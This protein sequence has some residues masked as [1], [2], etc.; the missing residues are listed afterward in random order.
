LS[1]LVQDTGEIGSI[2]TSFGPIVVSAARFLADQ[3]TLDKIVG[4][5]DVSDT[6][7]NVAANLLALNADPGVDAITAD[8]G[9]GTLSGAGV[10][11]PNFSET[12]WGTNLTVS[13]ALLTYAGA[14]T[15]GS[16]STLSISS[17]DTLSLTGTASLS[18]TTSGLG[19]LALGGSATIDKGGT[20]SVSDW[21]ISGAGADVKL[22]KNLSYAGS[23]S[24]G[25]DDT[26]MLSG[27]HLL[28][29]GAATFAGG[30]VE[31]SN[32]LYTEGTTTVS[33]LT[34]GGTVEW[35]NTSAVNQSGGNVTLGDNI[36][37]DEAI[38]YNTPKATYDIIDDSG[39]GLGASTASYIHNGGLLEKTGGTETSTIAP[40]VTNTGTIKVAAATLDL[41]GA[42]TG[43]GSDEISGA[44]TLQFDA[45]V[46][47]DQTV[48][49]SGVGGEVALHKP[50]EFAGQISGFDTTNAGSKDKIEVAEHWVFTGFKEN[51]GS[52]TLGFKNNAGSTISH[53]LIG[54]YSG[55]FT[56]HTQAN[57][58]TVITYTGAPGLDSLLH[59]A[60]GAAATGAQA[61]SASPRQ[62]GARAA[63]GA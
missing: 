52:T 51:A 61:D 43:K 37:A 41:Q 6:A 10:N 54:N 14:F 58:S 34:I 5:F 2:T 13:E 44:S 48:D 9:D 28:L 12:G 31:G 39:I 49:F 19:T 55:T 1:T 7:G 4:G 35:E 27:G 47:A 17:A 59:P 15:Q 36:A 21:S 42:V 46:A 25:A 62:A 30:T 50:G 60:G 23:F 53:T 24:E 45:N 33:G 16:G 40:S 18:G 20:I 8:I 3:S 11:A 32:F 56:P 63:T 26:F 38:L 57:G 22:D 29:S